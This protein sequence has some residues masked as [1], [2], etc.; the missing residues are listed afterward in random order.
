MLTP[1][2]EQVWLDLRTQ[3]LRLDKLELVKVVRVPLEWEWLA[4]QA[5]DLVGNP[6]GFQFLA[7]DCENI[8]A[9][10]TARGIDADPAAL[11]DLLLAT[12]P[13]AG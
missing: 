6:Q 3:V 10:F 12:V 1:S 13:H 7:R 4:A 5:V 11:R 8:C 9:W 2:Q